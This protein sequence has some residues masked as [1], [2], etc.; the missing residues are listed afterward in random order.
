MAT[1]DVK[2]SPEDVAGL[3]GLRRGISHNALVLRPVDRFVDLGRARWHREVLEVRQSVPTL[4]ERQLPLVLQ[5]IIHRA[6]SM[7][8]PS[9]ARRWCRFE[10]HDRESRGWAR[11]AA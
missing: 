9:A 11:P 10:C 8:E 3:L 5:A 6:Q 7:V 1:D 4:G 2:V